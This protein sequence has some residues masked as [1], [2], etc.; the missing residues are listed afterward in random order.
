MLLTWFE[1]LLFCPPDLI[2]TLYIGFNEVVWSFCVWN[3]FFIFRHPIEMHV[4]HFK[5]CYLTQEAALREH[6]GVVILV[7]FF[8]VNLYAAWVL[9][10]F[11]NFYYYSYKVI[12]IPMFKYFWT[13]QGKLEKQICLS[14]WNVKIY[15]SYWNHFK[16]IISCTGGL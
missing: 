10:M 1:Y 14:E 13:L 9:L 12:R 5:S 16:A 8:K 2:L 6:D 7:Y 15:I 4:V 11:Y 3:I